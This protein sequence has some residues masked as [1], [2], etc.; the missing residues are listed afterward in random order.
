MPR[1]VGT[2][3]GLRQSMDIDPARGPFRIHLRRRRREDHVDEGRPTRGEIGFEGPG[4]AFEIPAIIEL[5]RVH[6]DRDDDALGVLSRDR[7]KRR[8]APVES[9]HRGHEGHATSGSPLGVGPG[10]QLALRLDDSHVFDSRFR[11]WELATA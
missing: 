2:A 1:A 11:S 6:E 4:I 5:G 7:D 9:A 10:L 3:E 8:V